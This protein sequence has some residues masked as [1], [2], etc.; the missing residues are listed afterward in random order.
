MQSQIKIFYILSLQ[1]EYLD[2][3]VAYDDFCM[4]GE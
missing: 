4:A 1:M 2:C 3:N